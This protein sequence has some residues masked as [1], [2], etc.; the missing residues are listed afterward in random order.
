M[1]RIIF[2]ELNEVP[3]SIL[4]Y[5]TQKYPQSYVARVLSESTQYVTHCADKGHLSPW[6]TWPTMHRGVNNE[7][8]QIQDF[9]EDFHEVDEKYPPIWKILKQNGIDVGMFA[10]M[11]SYP[12]PKDYFEYAFYVPDPFAGEST[13]HPKNLQ[14]FQD[15]NLVMSR[16]SGRNVDAGIDFK[17]AIGAVASFPSIGIRPST[18]AAVGRQL[19]TERTQPHLKTRRR[20][21]QA[22]L[23]FD[24]FMKLLKRT[25][26]QFCTCF[27]NHAASTMHRYWAATFPE[28]YQDYELSDTWRKQYQGEIDF[29]IQK[30]DDFLRPLV[31]FV[32]KNPDFQ[33]VVAS[34]MGQKATEAKLVKSEAYAKDF[35]K[36]IHALGLKADQWQLRAA[37]HPQYNLQV[38]E[39]EDQAHLRHNLQQLK[40]D[41]QPISFREK[42][43]GFFSIDL[44]HKNLASDQLEYQGQS[45]PFADFGLTNEPIEDET[46]STAYHIPEGSL[47]V[48]DPQHKDV[49]GVREVVDTRAFAPSVL[50]NFGIPAAEYMVK[51]RFDAIG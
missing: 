7:L 33:L 8:H 26:P 14:P 38:P 49:T 35:P 3:F 39:E 15:F 28:Q 45:R 10:S 5:F 1:R 29:V 50:S 42:E 20:T 41:G 16:K 9:G 18:L 51:E 27:S 19:A 24:T 23:A 30:F 13:V 40:I 12:P 34:S 32:D 22:V 21:Y 31:H 36:L 37:M 17:T 25:K 46:G 44:G 43:E 11:H 6:I 47:F 48:Y 2:F 4:D